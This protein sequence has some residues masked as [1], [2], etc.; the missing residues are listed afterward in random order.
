MR[1][2][3][4]LGIFLSVMVP[5]SA[6]AQQHAPTMGHEHRQPYAGLEKRPIKAL[7]DRQLADLRAGRGMGLALSAELNGYPGPKH[8]LDHADNLN[9][10][11]DQRSKIKALFE[12]MQHRAIAAGKAVIAAE[13]KLE[14]IFADGT[15]DPA[16]LH[17]AMRRV[18]DAQATLRRTHLSYHISTRAA[19]T[20]TQ[21]QTYNRLRGYRSN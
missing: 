8:V 10:T 2:R 3:F 18:G 15:A 6:V 19:L 11:P 12:T 21:V 16:S 7:S 17:T 13:A 1:P 5:V 20:G 14:K 9:L 4:W